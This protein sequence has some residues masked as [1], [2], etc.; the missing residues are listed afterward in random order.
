MIEL[1]RA[2]EACLATSNV[3]GRAGLVCW[4]VPEPSKTSADNGWRIMTHVD[5][6]E[7]VND[8]A[9]WRVVDFNEVCNIE[10]MLIGIWDMPV[11]SDLRLVR[12]ELGLRIVDTVTGREVPPES[13]YVPP[14]NRA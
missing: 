2:V 13:F 4:M 9:N 12:D 8:T 7:Y 1:I 3:M 5:T 11:G 10:P 6:S 14:Q